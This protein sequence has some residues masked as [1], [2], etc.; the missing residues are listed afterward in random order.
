MY[1]KQIS[2]NSFDAAIPKLYSEI[3]SGIFDPELS[4]QNLRIGARSRSLDKK[5]RKKKKKPSPIAFSQTL[6]RDLTSSSKA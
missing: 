5:K 4:F 3:R 1:G 6:H 2:W